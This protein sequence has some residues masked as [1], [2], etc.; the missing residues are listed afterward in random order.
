MTYFCS[1]PISD[2][3]PG[4]VLTSSLARRIP[5]LKRS[6][7]CSEIPVQTKPD[8]DSQETKQGDENIELHSEEEKGTER[9]ILTQCI[10]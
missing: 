10:R 8:R 6:F 1:K 9:V 4:R 2:L 5:S 7:S 3:S